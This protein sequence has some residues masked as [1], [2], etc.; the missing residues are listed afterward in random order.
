MDLRIALLSD[1]RP[2]HFRQ[3]E[4][5]VAALARRRAV[6]VTRLELRSFVPRALIGRLWTIL[7]DALFL[8]LVH[9]LDAARLPADLVV[10][11]GA[12]TLGANAALAKAL[13]ARNVFAGSPRMVDAG[14]ISLVLTPYAKDAGQPNTAFELKP[15]PIDPDALPPVRAW[16][17]ER[18][19]LSLLLGGATAEVRFRSEDWRLLAR[20]VQ[21]AAQAWSAGWTIVSSR[22]TPS[23]AYAA[24]RPLAGHA[25]IRF[26]D[27][28]EAGV[29]SIA[30][31]LAADALFVTS[32]S[33]SMVSEAVAARRPVTVLQPRRTRPT[34]DA[35]AIRD[36]AEAGRLA[37]VSLAEATPARVD[38][39][40]CPLTPMRANHLDLLADT[41]VRRL[42]L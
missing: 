30:P 13:G 36:L 25:A 16:R 23:A 27:Y 9:G 35:Q 12:A 37:A 31:A 38:A 34:A 41:L 24:L 29:G 3:S 26:V 40:I 33:L 32:D 7:P 2:G 8:R 18:P 42:R 14:R 6:A 4:S 1:G 11:A 17:P 28:R 22:R 39:R 10:S 20:F 21:D 19:A 5:I 15:S